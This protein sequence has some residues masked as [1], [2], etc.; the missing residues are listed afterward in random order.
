[1]RVRFKSPAHP[2]FP[3]EPTLIRNR[4]SYRKQS[5]CLMTSSLNP[6]GWEGGGGVTSA[7]GFGWC[8]STPKQK[9]GKRILWRLQ[10]PEGQL[11]KLG[12]VEPPSSSCEAHCKLSSLYLFNQHKQVIPQ[13]EAHW[14]MILRPFEII[15]F[16]L[17]IIFCSSAVLLQ[18]GRPQERTENT[19]LERFQLDC[20]LYPVATYCIVT[21]QWL[22]KYINTI[23][24]TLQQHHE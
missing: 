11:G 10:C 7:C 17:C 6:Q 2:H 16:L 18:S 14:H 12:V 19:F 9:L 1:M 5:S 24:K 15:I 20:S 3:S 22:Y 13:K 8:F 4:A 23:Y 21:L